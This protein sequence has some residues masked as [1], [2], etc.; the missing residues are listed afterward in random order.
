MLTSI[1]FSVS[2]S[3][4][5]SEPL[6][7]VSNEEVNEIQALIESGEASRQD[8]EDASSCN[9][10]W[11]SIITL[12][13]KYP[14]FKDKEAYIVQSASSLPSHL[15]RTL[16]ALLCTGELLA[17]SQPAIL[18][19]IADNLCT[20]LMNRKGSIVQIALISL[21]EEYRAIFS[22]Y[23]LFTRRIGK[24]PA[25]SAQS[26]KK[27]LHAQNDDYTI[28]SITAPGV[29]PLQPNIQVTESTVTSRS[30]LDLFAMD[31]EMPETSTEAADG[32]SA[33]ADLHYALPP[34]WNI[35]EDEDSDGDDYVP[36][37]QPI[38]QSLY[39]RYYHASKD[40][41]IPF[42]IS[43]LNLLSRSF[44]ILVAAPLNSYRFLR[45]LSF[46]AITPPRRQSITRMKSALSRRAEGGDGSTKNT[47][48][49]KKVP[50]QFIYLLQ[51][52]IPAHAAIRVS[53]L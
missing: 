11:S 26:W 8:F 40:F 5:C 12:L 9:I 6:E 15:Q 10:L 41:A 53:R 1:L 46:I 39:H 28:P 22:Y 29:Q 43:S 7:I 45:R 36:G 34:G 3:K 19:Q 49:S 20:A 44:E 32:T 42:N 51:R 48:N 52:L 27:V 25:P 35:E 23:Y 30:S 38:Q 37:R 33:A 47:R 21:I 14:I 2:N 18:T 17:Q 13:S 16:G 24:S 31:F 4:R 50:T